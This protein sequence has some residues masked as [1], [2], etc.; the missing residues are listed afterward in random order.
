[1]ENIHET[2]LLALRLA[3][4]TLEKHDMIFEEDERELLIYKTHGSLFGYFLLKATKI[5]KEK[6]KL[7]ESEGV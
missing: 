3:C 6:E 4:E 7:H 5:L 1:M 2:L